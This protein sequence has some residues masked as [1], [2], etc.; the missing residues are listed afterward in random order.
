MGSF[1]KV[2]SIGIALTASG[3]C[4]Q[5]GMTQP[6]ITADPP[7]AP[8]PAPAALVMQPAQAQPVQSLPT[9]APVSLDATA[10][11]AQAST[12][13]PGKAATT[14]PSYII[15]PED[16]ISVTVWREPNLSGNLSVR[17][18]GKVSLPLLGDLQAAGMSPMQLSSDIGSR[19]KKYVNDPLV[20]VTVLAVNSKRIYLAGEVGRA[21]PLPLTPGM[22]PLQ[23]ILTA[24]G[25]TTFANGKKIYILRKVD[26]KE[27]KLPFNYKTAL[28]TGDMQGITLMS[29]DTIVVP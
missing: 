13:V 15:G 18:D 25:L 22:T 21:G 20:T 27:Q 14:D 29:G 8:A 24:G 26:G 7:A 23:A 16:S 10:T 12:Q 4:A 17:P 28:K 19:L 11:S 3:A 9:Q 5:Q 1:V 2:F 6:V